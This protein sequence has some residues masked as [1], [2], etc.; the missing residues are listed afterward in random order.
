[1]NNINIEK[2]K[3]TLKNTKK[4]VLQKTL[5]FVLAATFVVGAGTSKAEAANINFPTISITYDDDFEYVKEEEYKSG[6]LTDK[7]AKEVNEVIA[8]VDE[9]FAQFYKLIAN[10]GFS[11]EH[12]KSEENSMARFV[13]N[14]ME[15]ANNAIADFDEMTKT[16]QDT[17]KKYV[18]TKVDEAKLTYHNVTNASLDKLNDFNSDRQCTFVNS[19][20]NGLVNIGIYEIKNN[21]IVNYKI[22][23]IDDS[24][25]ST[26]KTLVNIPTIEVVYSGTKPNFK[27]IY[28]TEIIKEQ[29]LKMYNQAIGDVDIF[30][31]KLEKALEK[32]NYTKTRGQENEDLFVALYGDTNLINQTINTKYQ[33]IPGIKKAVNKYLNYKQSL[34]ASQV[35]SKNSINYKDYVKYQTNNTPLRISE[36]SGFAYYQN[37]TEII[38]IIDKGYIKTS[39]LR[40]AVSTNTKAEITASTGVNIY[41]DGKLYIPT[42]V[43]GK[44][45]EPFLY[46]G[47]TYLPARA[48]SN[49]F[50]TNIEWKNGSVYITSI[51]NDGTYYIDENGNKVYLNAYPEIP[52]TNKQPNANLVSKKL[53][54]SKGI[55]IYYNNNLF[56]PTDVNGNVVETYI[57]NGTTYLPARAISNLFGAEINWNKETNSVSINRNQF[58]YEDPSDDYYYED[59]NGNHIYVPEDDI[60]FGN[61]I[62]NKPYY[63]DENG[64][65]VYIG[66]DDYQK[67]R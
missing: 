49:V 59:S 2:I 20:Q 22:I 17:I 6:Y 16:Q 7:Q 46:N 62:I 26:D 5:P 9:D 34:L 60:D 18:E 14:I 31:S 12:T 37:G 32:G 21:S 50:N 39:D 13:A 65:K 19:L 30:Y 28:E 33:S 67:T 57:F 35:Y 44:V 29:D 4:L 27:V 8:Q 10:G 25:L 61:N 48:I 51:E 43:N 1:M 40:S 56:V 38:P 55:K 15:I 64:N 52:T 58:I 41:I 66:E 3:Q 23:S 11:F 24:K 36:E 45:V 42:D 63:Y 47:T 54:G 53:V